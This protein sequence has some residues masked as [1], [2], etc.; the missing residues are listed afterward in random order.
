MGYNV[1]QYQQAG[2]YGPVTLTMGWSSH[3]IC[4]IMAVHYFVENTSHPRK[5]LE[6]GD[7][8]KKKKRKTERK[9]KKKVIGD[10]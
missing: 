6:I 9:K 10:F 1:P 8:K 2:I 3:G 7:F 5:L 4:Y